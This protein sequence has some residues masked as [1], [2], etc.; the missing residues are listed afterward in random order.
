MS[1]QQNTSPQNSGDPFRVK[2]TDFIVKYE[3]AITRIRQQVR[4]SAFALLCLF[5][6]FQLLF[7]VLPEAAHPVLHVVEVAFFLFYTLF[8]GTRAIQPLVNHLYLTGQ[9]FDHALREAQARY[10]ILAQNA[11]DMV[12]QFTS[13][14]SLTYVSPASQ[15]LLGYA[16]EQLIDSTVDTLLHPDDQQP[17]RQAHLALFASPQQQGLQLRLRHRDGGFVWCDCTLRTVRD[18]RTGSVLQ[19]IASIRDMSQRK[20]IEVALG[21]KEAFIER[22]ARTVPAMIYVYD[23]VQGRITYANRR[24]LSE[25]HYSIEEQN[26]KVMFPTVIHPED[27]TRVQETTQAVLRAGNHEMI[28]VEYRVRLRSGEWGWVRSVY[29]VFQRDADGAPLSIVGTAQDITAHK[30]AAEQAITLNSEKARA[31]FLTSFINSVSHDFRTP[32]TV[33]SSSLYFLVRLPDEQQR[34]QRALLVEQQI[35]TLQRLMDQ[36]QLI[37][38]LEVPGW[39]TFAPAAPQDI[40]NGVVE[41]LDDLT[42]VQLEIVIEETPPA[43][44]DVVLLRVML[45]HLLTNALQHSQRE[46]MVIIR[47]YWDA[48]CGVVIEVQDR[49]AGI[50]TAELPHIFDY[51][52]RVDKA[53]ARITGGIGLGL[54]IVRKIVDIHQAT[55]TVESTPAQGSTFRVCI[56]QWEFSMEA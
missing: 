41:E 22:V 2:G 31:E 21:E 7:F 14:G 28:S 32:L 9:A 47:S 52:Y 5:V 18:P 13:D 4:A 1:S 33:I 55:I 51:F 45:Q 46:A 23:F 3:D 39:Y 48:T 17:F 25:Q 35:T 42:R 16:P 38:H 36:I 11:T 6:S 53:R 20:A 34:Q 8:L 54:S 40:I 19:I 24:Q 29:A 15:I 12:T 37:T 43:R 10:D 49:G 26:A 56:P 50:P 44:G 30:Q 27:V